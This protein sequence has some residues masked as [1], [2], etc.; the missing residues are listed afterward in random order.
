MFLDFYST[1]NIS[2]S[3][4]QS[5]GKTKRMGASCWDADTRAGGSGAPPILGPGPARPRGARGGSQTALSDPPL[6]GRPCRPLHRVAELGLPAGWEE[7]RPPHPG[8]VLIT[9]CARSPGLPLGSVSTKPTLAWLLTDAGPCGSFFTSGL[10]AF[11]PAPPPWNTMLTPCP[12]PPTRLGQLPRQCCP[13]LLLSVL[14][15]FNE[16]RGQRLLGN[17]GSVSAGLWFVLFTAIP[18]LPVAMSIG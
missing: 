16:P 4:C 6:P 13:H 11:A 9:P 5:E 3:P 18:P 17:K 8:L 7:E 14:S 2:T 15:S 10:R 12:E 1:K